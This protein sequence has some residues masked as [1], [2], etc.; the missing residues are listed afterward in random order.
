MEWGKYVYPDGSVY[1][2]EWR[3]GK[4]HGRGTLMYSTGDRYA[5]E[6]VATQKQGQGEFIYSNGGII[7]NKNMKK[8]RKEIKK[9]ELIKGR[10][11]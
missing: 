7:N 8:R 9:K 1:E 2:G 4:A 6:W 11:L 5:G 3:G 10:H